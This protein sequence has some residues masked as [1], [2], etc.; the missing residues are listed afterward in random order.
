MFATKTPDERKVRDDDVDYVVSDTAL[1]GFIP[2]SFPVTKHS[3]N[4]RVNVCDR[5]ADSRPRGLPG[6]NV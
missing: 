2:L 4:S 6:D 3:R 5:R 1:R